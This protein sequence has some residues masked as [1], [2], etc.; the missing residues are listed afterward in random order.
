MCSWHVF[1]TSVVGARQTTGFTG[2]NCRLEGLS[3]GFSY[4]SGRA[5][6]SFCG[7]E[8]MSRIA[9]DGSS[10]GYISFRLWKVLFMFATYV[11]TTVLLIVLVMLA[12][13][14]VIVVMIAIIAI[15]TITITTTITITI[16]IIINTTMYA[17]KR[18]GPDQQSV[19]P[20][21]AMPRSNAA[22]SEDSLD[23]FNS[24]E[25]SS[26]S[27]HSLPTPR[28]SLQLPRHTPDLLEFRN[29][30]LLEL[31]WLHLE[32]HLLDGTINRRQPSAILTAA[33][34]A[35]YALAA[36][37][38][39]ER[40]VIRL[41]E[42]RAASLRRRYTFL[43]QRLNRDLNRNDI[44]WVLSTG[45][46]F[47]PPRQLLLQCICSLAYRTF[48]GRTGDPA[49]GRNHGDL[50]LPLWYQPAIC[51]LLPLVPKHQKAALQQWYAGYVLNQQIHHAAMFGLP[52][53]ICR[54]RAHGG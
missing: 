35:Q 25:S 24:V 10:E 11:G 48:G 6:N 3:L 7:T 22:P 39:M 27:V 4:W 28:E 12:I 41:N 13:I 19:L 21:F 46:S 16:T 2:F 40:I 54:S 33:K 17:A 9:R 47:A 29:R 15:I 1:S 31:C 23:S 42:E 51:A 14:V 43:Q 36:R 38:V 52:G 37:D 8:V 30:M 34:R 5:V 45:A 32:E 26:S 18:L 44:R 53:P 49:H 50:A 20:P